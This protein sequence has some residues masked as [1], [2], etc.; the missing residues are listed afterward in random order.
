MGWTMASDLDEQIEDLECELEGARGA[1]VGYRAH[2]GEGF[3]PFK[4]L[5]AEY[6]RIKARLEKLKRLRDGE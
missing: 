1:M 5:Q 3:P 6:R 4:E 2:R